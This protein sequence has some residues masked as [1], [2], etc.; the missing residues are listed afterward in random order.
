MDSTIGSKTP[1]PRLVDIKSPRP[2][3]MGT[4]SSINPTLLSRRRTSRSH[5][6]D[7][8]DTV[9]ELRGF[10]S[11]GIKSSVKT[12]PRQTTSQSYGSLDTTS[13]R[14][15]R[16]TMK[17]LSDFLM[18]YDPPAHNLVAHPPTTPRK[19]FGL[20][21][22]K[23]KK[24]LN[25]NQYLR[26]PD[27]AIAAKT[28]QGVQYIAIS[29]PLEHDY[30][31]RLPTHPQSGNSGLQL[32]CTSKFNRG[33]IVV[34]KPVC[35]VEDSLPRP[36]A[37]STLDRKPSS[38]KRNTWGPGT[39]T[40][41]ITRPGSEEAMLQNG[42]IHR[43]SQVYTPTG[44]NHHDAPEIRPRPHSSKAIPFSGPTLKVTL[45]DSHRTKSLNSVSRPILWRHRSDGPLRVIN[46]TPSLDV[47]PTY[48]THKV[49]KSI[50]TIHSVA[51][52]GTGI[53]QSLKSTPDS[54]KTSSSTPPAVFGTAETIDFQSFR[55]N[56]QRPSLAS[57]QAEKFMQSTLASAVE[58]GS[59]P[60]TEAISPM[61]SLSVNSPQVGSNEKRA[62]QAAG[63]HRW[64]KVRAKKERD[65]AS[66]RSKNS[67]LD[68]TNENRISTQSIPDSS[69]TEDGPS[70][71]PNPKSIGPPGR[72]AKRLSQK[73][74]V[75][76]T[77]N[78]MLV[79]DL[80]PFVGQIHQSNFN[81]TRPLS[82]TPSVPSPSRL[83]RPS[84]ITTKP[85]HRLDMGKSVYMHH[86]T[87]T[88]HSNPS[89]STHNHA[90]PSPGKW[91]KSHH[92]RP[93]SEPFVYP[94]LDLAS[95]DH[96]V[97]GLDMD[98]GGKSRMRMGMGSSRERELDV[99]MRIIERDT[100]VLLRTL[101]GIARSF[102]NL[103]SFGRMGFGGRDKIEMGEGL[104]GRGPKSSIIGCVGE[105]GNGEQVG[106]RDER[107]GRGDGRNRKRAATT[108]MENM[109][110]DM[111]LVMREI[112]RLAPRVSEESMRV[113]EGDAEGGGVGAF[114]WG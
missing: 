81:L 95:N 86:S 15:E 90:S 1:P 82:P 12:R 101:G 56:T 3:S 91:Q 92:T 47:K 40:K 37:I 24:D 31:E 72:S 107:G 57:P 89:I 100:D 35:N 73:A 42:Y 39:L 98:L 78:I 58:P 59:T 77:S 30:I 113:G 99:R 76:S 79:A 61:T 34:H 45:V 28:R 54:F 19:R 75:L 36:P 26:L 4:P 66:L 62:E 20:L 21:R 33:P 96:S 13:P 111:D 94:R 93:N 67:S 32:G 65:L 108:G 85:L 104:G 74:I 27:T 49:I 97:D 25:S 48:Q 51:T 46:R 38:S 41:V 105:G 69:P 14:H 53:R 68:K 5:N 109:D 11:S 110:M 80:P 52:T 23:Q 43:T 2:H 87:Q 88:Q 9:P 102:D 112:Q 7:T 106:E 18:S 55:G 84:F 16:E 29:I 6:H 22:R 70:S 71:S 114:L 10:N 17:D 63:I 103:G 83:P 8:V 60:V 50:S 44:N 64:E